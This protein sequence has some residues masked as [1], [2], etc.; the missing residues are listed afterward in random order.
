MDTIMPPQEKSIPRPYKCPYPLCGRAFSRLEHQVRTP[1]F[2][3]GAP[4]HR[5]HRQHPRYLVFFLS[6]YLRSSYRRL[7]TFAHTLAKSHLFVHTRHVKSAF[8]AQTNLL[9]THG[10]TA[11]ITAHQAPASLA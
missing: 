11:M 4:L 2:L 5:R 10:Y 9:V 6:G 7:A 1:I 3:L 8:P